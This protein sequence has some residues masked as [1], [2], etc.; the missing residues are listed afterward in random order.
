MAT[1]LHAVGTAV[2]AH[3][4]EQSY[5]REVMGRWLDGDRRTHKL[6]ER[7]Y[8]ASAIDARHSV[9]DDFLPDREPASPDGSSSHPPLFLDEETGGFRSAT[10]GERNAR[11][12]LEAGP[13]AVR[14]AQDAFR[15]VRS[16]RP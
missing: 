10:T 15:R 8:G 6:L 9:L 11:Y 1:V 13:L 2:P 7:V 12:A 5:V 4:Y 14:A 3:R 16:L